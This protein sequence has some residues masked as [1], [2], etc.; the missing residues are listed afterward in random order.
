MSRINNKRNVF[1]DIKAFSSK[2]GNKP[3]VKDSY[4]SVNNSKDSISFMLDVLKAIAGTEALKFLIG[5][6]LVD[7]LNNSESQL[8]SGLKKQFVQSNADN[9]LPEFD[10]NVKVKTLD[11]KKKLKVLPTDEEKGGNLLYGD[12]KNN[13]DRMLRNAINNPS[14]NIPCHNTL[15]NYNPDND[16]F[17][18]KPIDV[19][20]GDYFNN[21][22]DNTNIINSDEIV[23]NAMDKLF[24]TL[25]KSQNK[26][27]EEVLDEL[28]TEKIL[29]NVLN[30]EDNPYDVNIE[31]YPDLDLEAEQISNSLVTYDINCKIVQGFIPE[32]IEYEVYY[33]ELPMES[34]QKMMVDINDSNK[35]PNEV[36][37]IVSDIMENSIN[38]SDDSDKRSFKDG[39]FVKFIK[40]IILK[41]L[42]AVTT[43]P[44]VRMLMAIY[45]AIVN[46][47]EVMLE[48][49]KDDLKKW[50]RIIFCMKKEIMLIVGAFIFALVVKYLVKLIKPEIKERMKERLESWENSLMSLVSTIKSKIL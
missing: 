25:S 50:K 15:V 27:K 3:E 32:E 7:I 2:S 14:S 4:S 5:S 48:K 36:G 6:F 35:N 45:S 31:N 29:E 20:V 33:G 34:L 42:E 28:L 49:A 44:Q 46:N 22:I 9:S 12:S 16:S 26:T 18:L 19:N 1:S 8:K 30:D 11:S 39:F 24:G 10:V 17:L 37:N 21:F 38:T 23:G 13:G 47:G 40:T 43:A 41:L